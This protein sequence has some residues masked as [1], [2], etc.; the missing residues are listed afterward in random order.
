MGKILG[1]A[2]VFIFGNLLAVGIAVGFFLLFVF[3][4]SR[5]EHMNGEKWDKWFEKL[6]VGKIMLGAWLFYIPSLAVTTFS[7]Y[8][9]LTMFDC[10]NAEL[11]TFVFV[12]LALLN[13]G[14]SMFSKRKKLEEKVKKLCGSAEA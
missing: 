8:N 10:A 3:S 9:I 13:V 4:K 2:V 12:V 11:I 5:L 7:T 6:S 1:I 14:I